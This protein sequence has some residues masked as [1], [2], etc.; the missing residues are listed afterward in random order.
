MSEEPY[1]SSRATSNFTT[2]KLAEV[3]S[4]CFHNQYDP[5]TNPDG[6]IALAVAENKLMRDE[7]TQYINDNTRIR[8]WHLTYGEGPQ[9]TTELLSELVQFVKKEF[10]PFKPIENGH[11][12]VCN[13]AGNAVSQ[14]GFCVGE[15]GD[16]I[17][18]G[19][20]LYVGFFPDIE[21]HAK[22]KAVLVSFGDIDPLSPESASCYEEALLESNARGTTIRALLISNPHNPLGRPY[23]SETLEAY[24]KVCAKHNIHLL[25]DEVYCK[26]NFPSNDIPSPYPFIS[27]LSLNLSTMINPALVHII[28]A[29]SKDFCANGI[30]IG[31]LISPFN[32]TLFR[33]F[34]SI[35]AFT[36][37]SHLAEVAWLSL[38]Q[39]TAPT[40]SWSNYFS[41]LESR[42]TDS[43]NFTTS[44]LKQHSI[45]YTTAS[46]T[47]FIWLNLSH[48]LPRPQTFQ[49]ELDL[50]LR[51]AHEAHIWLAAGQSFGAEDFGWYR[52]TF[53]SPREELEEGLSRLVG[54]LEEV[55]RER[56]G[57][58][59][60]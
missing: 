60:R 8:P 37:P 3:R 55:E 19:R 21:N 11:I 40:G 48:Y 15:P 44:I 56:G 16:G 47:S 58:G 4:Y 20:P 59:E 31:A 41:L 28:Y 38:L 9:G 54:L 35:A 39:A 23:P 57:R 25:S 2:S 51:M 14:F 1:I 43:Y 36:R 22:T 42:M 24:L 45:P 5:K 32:P 10:H 12:C 49:A 6:V 27:V 7:I 18:V 29:M 52:L 13:G 53:A 33:A 17:L 30:R 50:N 46:S 34:R 26:S